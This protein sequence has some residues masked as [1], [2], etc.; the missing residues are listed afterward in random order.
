MVFAVVPIFTQ[1]G[2]P[3]YVLQPTFGYLIGF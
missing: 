3:A 1:G 2:G